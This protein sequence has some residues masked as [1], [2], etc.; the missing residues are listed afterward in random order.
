MLFLLIA[1]TDLQPVEPFEPHDTGAEVVDTT[2]SA[3]PVEACDGP[4][5]PGSVTVYC[6]D[7]SAGSGTGAAWI[8][9]GGACGVGPVYVDV[10]EGH[11][12]EVSVAVTCGEGLV[13]V[14]G[15]GEC[16]HVED[17]GARALGVGWWV[18]TPAT[19]S[20]ASRVGISVVCR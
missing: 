9:E 16:G 15:A 13:L 8:V 12:A 3:D 14:D 7:V 6:D 2:D 11:V 1:C 18:L 5:G 20:G 17:G 4:T 19:F 10:Y